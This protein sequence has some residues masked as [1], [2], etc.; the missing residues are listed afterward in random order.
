MNANDIVV[1]VTKLWS[2]IQEL[3]VGGIGGIVAYM[4]EYK[5]AKAADD[6]HKWSNMTMWIHLFMGSFMAYVVGQFMPADMTYRDGLIGLVGLTSYSIIGL[7]ENRFATWL[8]DIV[9]AVSGGN[10]DGKEKR[11]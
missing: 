6:E 11:G 9:M 5:R 10:K 1:V 8:V 2:A 3:T 4:V 7:V